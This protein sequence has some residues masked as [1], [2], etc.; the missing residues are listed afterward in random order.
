MSAVINQLFL[1]ALAQTARLTRRKARG[2]NQW[3]LKS[4]LKTWTLR[5]TSGG[6]SKSTKL[7]EAMRVLPL[8]ATM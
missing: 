4:T 3:S 5:L 7:A 8:V 2:S 1:E 6:S